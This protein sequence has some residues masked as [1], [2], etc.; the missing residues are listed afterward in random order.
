[1]SKR[2]RRRVFTVVLVI[3]VLTTVGS[4]NWAFGPFNHMTIDGQRY[5][6]DRLYEN[7]WTTTDDGLRIVGLHFVTRGITETEWGYEGAG[8]RL[9][10]NL[11]SNTWDL[12]GGTYRYDPDA[13]RSAFQ[14]WGASVTIGRDYDYG[15]YDEHYTIISG[16]IVLQ[17][18]LVD[19]YIVEFEFEAREGINPDPDARRVTITGRYRGRV[20]ERF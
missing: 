20:T 13:D 17:N 16:Q 7:R 3:L 11:F 10:M 5:S 15:G 19:G 8:D 2:N 4:C 1:M 9:G 6:L 18:L 12:E 14:I